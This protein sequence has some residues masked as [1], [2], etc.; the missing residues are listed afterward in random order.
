MLELEDRVRAALLAESAT[1]VVERPAVAPQAAID[2]DLD[3][4]EA[5]LRGE[6]PNRL[7]RI[8]ANPR[9][10]VLSKRLAARQS[11]PA[12]A[13]RLAACG[14]AVAVRASG[15]TAVVHRPGILNVSIV[16]LDEAPASMAR[17]Y[18]EL[19]SFLTRALARLGVETQPGRAAGASCDG[20]HNLL[21]QGRKLAGTAAVV[22]RR[23]GRT[24]RLVHA[25]LTVWG[26]PCDDLRLVAC[27]EAGLALGADYVCG[28]HATVALA[29]VTRGEAPRR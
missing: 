16:S 12:V 26:D 8:W 7:V 4:L 10:V 6:A 23:E 29:L 13:R 19:T 5:V 3:L 2:R 11:L 25:S 9:C 22:R 20:D 27:A 15:G 18:T 1:A 28:A 21:W 24:A 14:A 17:A